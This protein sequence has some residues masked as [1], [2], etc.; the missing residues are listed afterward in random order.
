MVPKK[1]P[2]DP[3]L[4]SWVEAQRN[5]HNREWKTE[6]KAGRTDSG[7]SSSED[8]PAPPPP[9]PAP[10][11]LVAAAKSPEEWALEMEKAATGAVMA[12]DTTTTTTTGT[13]DDV[14]AAAMQVV[15]EELRRQL[16]L[17]TTAAAA[18]MEQQQDEKLPAKRLTEERK[19]MLDHLGFV[20]SLRSKRTD[21]HWDEMYR[22]L[23][24]YKEQHGVSNACGV[25]SDILYECDSSPVLTRLY[26]LFCT[27][28]ALFRLDTKQTSSLESGKFHCLRDMQHLFL[29]ILISLILF[30]TLKGLRRSAM[31]LRSS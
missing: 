26:W 21:D 9:P 17:P 24:E 3:K 13:S 14:E 12:M 22:Q 31:N 7:S 1:Y 28:T 30:S 18:A 11:T 10:A 16:T 6:G 5:L 4:A 20:W 29:A 8:I 27:R 2:E 23:V 19:N 25:M 15:D